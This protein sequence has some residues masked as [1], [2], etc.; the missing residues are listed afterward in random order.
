MADNIDEE[1]LDSPTNTHSNNPSDD[2]I[3]ITE[4]EII[5]QN[6]ETENMEVHHHPDLH[7]KPKK[8]KEYFLEFLMI[9][10]AV[11]MGFFAESYREHLVDQSKERDYIVQLKDDLREDM[12]ECG[13]NNSNSVI[14]IN[15]K[16]RNNCDTLIDILSKNTTSR[17]EVVT[18]YYMYQ[19][20]MMDWFT[21]YFQDATWSQLRN[22]G[23]FRNIGNSK[24]VREINDYYKWAGVINDYRDEIKERYSA[25]NYNEGRKVFDQRMEKRMLDSIDR[26]GFFILFDPANSITKYASYVSD[27]VHIQFTRHDAETMLG[28]CNDLRSYKSLL[29]LYS[30]MINYQGIRAEKLVQFLTKEYRLKD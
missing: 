9:F 25:I 3:P 8:W 16:I 7:H 11:T 1:H 6:Q 19:R 13:I 22:N 20:I 2:I 28:L 4:A 5:S 10:L 23:G 27:T 17:K 26:R 30:G 15:A 14:F 24:V 18:A 12:A 21:A 29:L